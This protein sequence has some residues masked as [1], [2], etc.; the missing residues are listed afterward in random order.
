MDCKN[1]EEK[2]LMMSPEERQTF[3]DNEIE[4]IKAAEKSARDLEKQ[5]EQSLTPVKVTSIRSF[6]FYIIN[7]SKV[8]FSDNLM[9]LLRFS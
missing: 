3:F 1:R 2:L 8:V 5:A 4:S 7:K 6:K 9:T